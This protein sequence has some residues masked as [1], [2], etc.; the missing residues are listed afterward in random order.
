MNMKKSLAS[1]VLMMSAFAAMADP[2][3]RNEVIDTLTPKPNPCAKK[4]TIFKEEEGVIKTIED[5]KLI[6][7]GKCKKRQIKTAKNYIQ[8]L[9][10]GLNRVI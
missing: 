2:N 1:T 9:T 6:K 10:N 7:Q 3:M 8:K 5:Y 4:Y